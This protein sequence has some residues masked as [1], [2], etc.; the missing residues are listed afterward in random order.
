MQPGAGYDAHRDRYDVAILLL[1]GE[2]ETL[3]KK[4]DPFSAV[5]YS[6]GEIH[7]LKNTGDTPA[8]YLVFEFHP[9][10]ARNRWLRTGLQLRRILRSPM[11]KIPR[12]L[13]VFAALRSNA[14]SRMWK[15]L[16]FS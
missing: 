4:L 5:Y 1:K 12:N 13:G 6:A 7:G 10:P 9:G 16:S 2:V 14:A 8:Y 11:K 15:R 3:G